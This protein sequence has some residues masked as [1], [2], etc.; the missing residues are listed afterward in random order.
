MNDL[1]NRK[2]E[3]DCTGTGF[4]GSRCEI[5]INDCLS[6]GCHGNATCVDGINNYTCVCP[7]GFMGTLCDININDCS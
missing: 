7:Q 4:E 3:C 1:E 2:Y 5:N 6:N